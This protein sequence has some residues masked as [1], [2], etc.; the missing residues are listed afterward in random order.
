VC[1]VPHKLATDAWSATP[2]PSSL[3]A[4]LNL[5]KHLL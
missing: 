5:Q 4:F 3:I 1:S 2:L